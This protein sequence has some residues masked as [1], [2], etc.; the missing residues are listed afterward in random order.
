MWELTSSHLANLPCF[1]RVALT[2]RSPLFI[3]IT[4]ALVPCTSVFGIAGKYAFEMGMRG[5]IAFL[6]KARLI[7]HFSATLRAIVLLNARMG[8]LEDAARQL[9][10]TYY[11]NETP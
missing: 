3:L 5:Q 9:I 6:S 11:P 8:I 10:N 4:S 2:I 7:N 1:L